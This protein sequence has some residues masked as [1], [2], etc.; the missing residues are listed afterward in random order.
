MYLPETVLELME[1]LRRS[2]YQAWAVGGRADSLLG[3][4]PHD[5]DLCTNAAPAQ[6]ER[7]FAGRELVLAGRK[8]GTVGVVTD[9]GVVEITTYRTEGDYSTAATP[10]GCGSSPRCRRIWPAGISPSMPWPMPRIGDWWIPSAERMTCERAFSGRWASL[11]TDLGKMPCGSCGLAVCP[12]GSVCGSRITHGLPMNSESGGLEHLARER[13]FAELTGFLTVCDAQQLL[14]AQDILG[15]V[16]PE[17]KDAMGFCQHSPHHAYD[18]FTHIAYVTGAVEP[19]PELRFAALL[20]DVGKPACF[21]RDETGRGHF[22]GHADRGAQMAEEILTRLKAPTA[23][24]EEVVW[25]IGHHMFD[26]VPEPGAAR[27]ALSRYG[28][29]RMRRLIG[30]GTGGSFRQGRGGRGGRRRADPPLCAASGSASA[31]G[32]AL[33]LEGSGGGRPGSHGFGL[34]PGA[35]AGNALNTLLEQVLGEKLPQRKAGASHRRQA[36]AVTA[37]NGYKNF[38][39]TLLRQGE[40]LMIKPGKR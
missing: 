12:P 26:P 31:A 20:H 16:I 7:V 38:P 13:V 36:L 27:R 23:F 37:A 28:Y 8:H 10:G 14:M 3:I 30:I 39:L 4:T 18:V 34:C 29:D 33:Y 24:R 21:T 19:E 1:A 6:M 5:Y 11:P 35:G 22:Y 17:L 2:G 40:N 15:Q 9:M 25:L 32:G